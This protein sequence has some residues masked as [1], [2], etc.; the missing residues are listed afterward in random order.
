MPSKRTPGRALRA[1]DKPTV[2]EHVATAR[3]ALILQRQGRTVWEIADTL[4]LSEAATATA[5]RTALSQ[6]ADLVDEAS[7]R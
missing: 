7:K 2:A 4:G 6:A 1:V 5:I 3:A